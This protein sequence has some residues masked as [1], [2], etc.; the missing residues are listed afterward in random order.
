MVVS[1]GTGSPLSPTT[2]HYPPPLH[3]HHHHHTTG[4]LYQVL[5]LNCAIFERFFLFHVLSQMI[6]FKES[7]QSFAHWVAEETIHRVKGVTPPKQWAEDDVGGTHLLSGLRARVG[8][9]VDRASVPVSGCELEAE[10]VWPWSCLCG[11]Q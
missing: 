7:L 11:C 4:I 3:H 2:L 5:P 1:S 8:L 10:E 9:G 6:T